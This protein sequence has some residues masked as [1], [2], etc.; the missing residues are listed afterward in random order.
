MTIDVAPIMGMQVGIEYLNGKD[1]GENNRFIVI[2]LF[3]I[4]ILIT[5]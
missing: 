1:F 3:I 2:N 5:L 4:T